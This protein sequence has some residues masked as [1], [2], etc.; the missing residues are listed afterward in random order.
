MYKSSVIGVFYSIIN[1][2][3]L[4]EVMILLV[5]SILELLF[6]YFIGNVWV[7]GWDGWDYNLCNKVSVIF[8][9]GCDNEFF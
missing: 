9:N 2:L 5:I 7:G 1:K 8:L 3:I 6:G 4:N